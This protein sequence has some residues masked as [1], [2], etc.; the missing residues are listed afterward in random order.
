MERPVLRSQ[1]PAGV[2]QEIYGL[3]LGHYVLRTLMC[4]AAKQ[5]PISPLRLSFVGTLKILR[6]RLPECPQSRP[7]RQK[8]W[9][10]LLQ[11]ISEEVIPPRRDR[12]N[13]RVIKRKMS[14]WPKKRQKHAH[15]PQPTQQFHNSIVVLR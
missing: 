9:R 7:A 11:E 5:V 2:V 14:N 10:N 15:W 1:T 12:I 8:W 3:M 13:P 6:C 4:E